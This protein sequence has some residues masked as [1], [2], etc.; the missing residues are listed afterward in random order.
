MTETA[1]PAATVAVLRDRLGEI[2]VFLVKRNAKTV[3]FPHAHV[4]PG[5]RVDEEDATVA[6]VGG[7]RD[8][9]RMACENAAA[10]QAA[11]IRETYEEAL[12]QQVKLAQSKEEANLQKLLTGGNSW[13]VED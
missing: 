6:I 4:F 3:F 1:R 2:E 11:A 12:S 8:R 7:E 13:V 9:E 5:G 10:Y